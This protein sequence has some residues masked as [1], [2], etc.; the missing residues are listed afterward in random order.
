[1]TRREIFALPLGLMTT[2]LLATQEAPAQTKDKPALASLTA[3][4]ADPAKH[5]GRFVRVIGCL[6]GMPLNDGVQLALYLTRNCQ[7]NTVESNAIM[8]D[9][10]YKRFEPASGKYV[11]FN[12]IFHARDGKLTF[13]NIGDLKPWGVGS[14]LNR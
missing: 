14:T 12:A 1:M 4:L 2:P 9:G 8:M 6:G 10:D 13:T 3:L 7:E 11:I 5:S